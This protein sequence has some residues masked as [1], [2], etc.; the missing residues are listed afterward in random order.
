MSR[1]NSPRDLLVVLAIALFGSGCYRLPPELRDDY[2]YEGPSGGGQDRVTIQMPFAQG[3]HSLCTQGAGGSYSHQGSATRYDVDFDTPNDRADLVY[4]PVYGVA[5]VHDDRPDDD[6]GIHVNIDL[7]DG[8][9]I[10]LGHLSQVFVADGQEVAPGVMLGY[11]GSTGDSSG[12]HVHVGRHQ[13]SASQDAVYGESLEGL[14]FT[15][16]DA[17]TGELADV[18][19]PDLICDLQGGHTYVSQL[20]VPLWHPDGTLVKTPS[21]STVYLLEDGLARPFTNE[22]VF[23][24]L[25]YDFADVVLVSDAEL[26]CFAFGQEIAGAHLI[27]GMYDE[28]SVWLLEDHDGQ[29]TAF[30]V[31]ASDWQAVLK[32][33]GIAA[34]TYDDLLTP[35]ELGSSVDAYDVSRDSAKLRDGTLVRETGDSTVY[36]I[37]G[38]IAMPVIDWDTF[39]LLGFGP[40]EVLW[41]DDG[42][43]T[44]V[45]GAVGDCGVNAFCLAPEDVVTCGG[46][47]GEEGAFDD[48][49]SQDDLGKQGEQED[50]ESEPAQAEDPGPDTL[51]LTWTTPMGNTV[52]SIELSGEFT[53]ADGSFDGWQ[54]LGEVY[55][56]SQIAYERPMQSGDTLRFSIEF[57]DVLETFWSCM[58]PFP[59]GDL[60]G[61][62]VAT[63]NG[64]DVPVV[65]ADDPASDGCGLTL[66]IP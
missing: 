63:W 14:A 61:E 17:N 41:V 9:Y 66:T 56:T 1:K 4:A 2:V 27:Q 20:P 42:T 43:V 10:V 52:Y 48:D 22:T 21:A 60:M 46:P 16:L 23:W 53:G 38:G 15:A 35:E 32:S 44:A 37:A 13:G 31:L 29:E 25:R 39:L 7:G 54:E 65:P 45:Q 36:A 11:E 64:I 19:T 12:D 33:W 18:S 57:E 34:S 40:R 6:F 30:E 3:Y 47:S 28:P 55:Q 26:A 24:D 51:S 58:A 59:P 49:A 62:A 8:T 50:E 5:Y